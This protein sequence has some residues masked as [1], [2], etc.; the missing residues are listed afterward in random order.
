MIFNSLYPM[1]DLNQA[2]FAILNI[3]LYNKYKI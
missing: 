2:N 1:R 3:M